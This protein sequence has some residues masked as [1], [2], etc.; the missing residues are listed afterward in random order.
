MTAPSVPV[1]RDAS[2]AWAY[3]VAC[4]GLELGDRDQDI[5][6][7]LHGRLDP[8]AASLSEA[9]QRVSLEKFL[10]EFFE[11]AQSYVYMFNAILDF[12]ESSG[13]T[14]GRHDWCLA[15]EGG[16]D[17]DLDHFRTQLAQWRS[18]TGSSAVPVLDL[19][20]AREIRTILITKGTGSDEDVTVYGRDPVFPAWLEAWLQVY[21]Q[22]DFAPLP[23]GALEADLPPEFHVIIP[24]IRAVAHRL[25]ETGQP[26]DRLK[27]E[28]N[29]RRNRTSPRDALDRWSLVYLETDYYLRFRL[30]ELYVAQT[31]DPAERVAIG[32]ALAAL[33]ARFPTRTL[34]IDISLPQFEELLRLPI[35][36]QRNELYAVWIAT[37]IANGLDEHVI[38]L[39]HDNGRLDFGFHETALATVLTADPAITV[40]CE[41]RSP[42]SPAA[43]STTRTEGVQPDYGLWECG[44]ND[45]SACVLAVE[46][47]HYKQSA[48]RRFTEVL[49][50]YAL[51][52][53]NAEVYL[54]NYGPIGDVL[55]PL[56]S[57]L[58]TRCFTIREL[59]PDN[60]QACSHLHDAVRKA[61]GPPS[62]TLKT[63]AQRLIEGNCIVVL[64]VSPS[65]TQLLGSTS[66]REHLFALTTQNHAAGIVTVDEQIREV[67]EPT[68]QGVDSA[69]RDSGSGTE[70]ST[71]VRR[72]ALLYKRIIAV[73][74]AEGLE[75]L[76][77]VSFVQLSSW[78][79]GV[80]VVEVRGSN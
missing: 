68:Q 20:A 63:A 69:L 49:S 33:V 62:P 4:G 65:M 60:L 53:P 48:G 21:R 11:V 32:R 44:S 26:R 16:V 39:H 59:T 51:S 25:A 78:N 36:Q 6:S 5:V 1:H 30:H 9:L 75:T 66:A 71:P 55:E 70:L 77:G 7:E 79:P 42:L 64:D 67:L 52:L 37:E 50:D 41:R 3:L 45:V 58:Q 8:T 23:P 46:C 15:L 80:R 73:T 76:A 17:L 14:R 40:Y 28:W 13:A 27:K 38:R 54:V 61:V 43:E 18:I 72:L 56:S 10:R 57:F 22:G 34:D 2:S 12:F 31:F 29:K 24:F 35:W 74:D 47:K 19:P